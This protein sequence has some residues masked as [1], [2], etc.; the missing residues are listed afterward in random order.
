MG[1]SRSRGG[2]PLCV[3]LLPAPL[4]R[5][6]L[7]DQAEDLLRAPRVVALGPGRVPYGA[8]ARLPASAAARLAALEARRLLRSL[9]GGAPR[10]VVIFHA[11]QEPVARAMV[12]AVPGCELWYWRWDRYE[13]AYDASPRMRARLAEMHEAA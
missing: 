10:V 7:R 12:D 3:L 6:I 5:F 1:P 4:D 11:L 9:R 8:Y 13:M 2:P